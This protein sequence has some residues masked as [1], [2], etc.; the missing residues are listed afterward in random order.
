LILTPREIDL[1]KLSPKQKLTFYE[2]RDARS[3]EEWNSK[4][5]E[6]KK[7]QLDRIFKKVGQPNP[8]DVLAKLVEEKW[9]ELT[10]RS[11]ELKIQ[12]HSEKVR[13]STLIVGRIRV[14]LALVKMREFGIN[15]QYTYMVYQPRGIPLPNPPPQPALAGYRRWIDLRCNSPPS[16]ITLTFIQN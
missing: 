16:H 4:Q 14:I 8:I 10:T 3:W 9:Q 5:R 6:R 12:K 13:I 2:C 11:A 7:A 15:P 1:K